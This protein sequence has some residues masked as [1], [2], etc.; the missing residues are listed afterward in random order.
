M[1]RPDRQVDPRAAKVA[2]IQKAGAA[3]ERRRSGLIWGIAAL[4]LALVVGSVVA[5]VLTDSPA[6]ADLGAVKDYDYKG[7]GHERTAVSYTENPPVGGPHNDAWWNCG[8]YDEEVPKEH[9]VHSLE[10][11][12]VWLTYQPD[13][14]ADQVEVLKKLGEQDY[15]LVSPLAD[16]KSP[17]VA[18][19]WGHQLALGS[20]D[21]RT[22]TAFIREYKQG[23]DTPEPGAAC[24]N[25]TVTD[26]VQ[27]G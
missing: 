14:P 5:A 25:G 6:T 15:M 21:E 20:A 11:G 9:A 1:P 16:Q 8:V 7:Q 18:S 13:L 2:K 17:V 27:R 23:P 19:S 10:H 22:L 24:T 12:A 4:V 3:A 26:L